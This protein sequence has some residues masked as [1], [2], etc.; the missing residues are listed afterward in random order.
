[1]ERHDSM[2]EFN[3]TRLRELLDYDQK[4][5]K[6]TWRVS[7]ARTAKAGS[8]AGTGGGEDY[9]RIMI[10]GKMYKAHRLAWLYVHGSWPSGQIDHIN[11]VRDDNRIDN[12]RDVTRSENMQNQRRPQRSNPHLGV[13]WCKRRKLWLA[14]IVVSGRNKFLGYYEQP[15]K[16][17]AAYL[18]AKKEHHAGYV[19]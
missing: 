13:T 14:Q 16:A 3:S 5:G 1:M 6:F 12:L 7:R 15:E 8:E 4:T 9:V 11:G 10:S 2:S 19:A 18:S 17:S